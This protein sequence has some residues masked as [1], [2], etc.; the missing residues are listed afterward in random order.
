[1]TEFYAHG[2]QATPSL[3]ASLLNDKGPWAHAVLSQCFSV[4]E[5]IRTAFLKGEME[6]TI[7]NFRILV[8]FTTESQSPP[9]QENSDTSS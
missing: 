7:P 6:W 1:M 8:I 2:A 9:K 4:P 3:V 5:H